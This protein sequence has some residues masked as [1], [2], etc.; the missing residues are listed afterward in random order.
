MV[1]GS[2]FRENKSY[3]HFA[4]LLKGLSTHKGKE[5]A[6]RGADSFCFE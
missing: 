4:S 6:L 3:S 5:L 2:P 1:N